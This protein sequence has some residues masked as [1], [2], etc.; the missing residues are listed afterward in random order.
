LNEVGADSFRFWAASE[1][2][3]G[4]DFR[5]SRERIVGASKFMTK[6]WNISKFISM[7]GESE[8]PEKL[9]ETDR[10]ILAELGKLIKECEKGYKSYDFFVPANTI[11]DFVWNIF[12]PHYIELVKSRAYEGNYSASYTL[13]TVL[14]NVLKLLA[15]ICPFM[16]DKIYRELYGKSVH[17]ELFPKTKKEWESKYTKLTQDL[18]D[19]NSAIWKEKKDKNMSLASDIEATIPKRLATF[20][21]DLKA[22]HR[23]K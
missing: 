17:K 21:R 14:K 5:I 20:E 1:T 19:F 11:R 9:E 15:P 7:F 23:L 13:H 22:M 10:W 6:L 12:A 8:E 18:V 4:D 2:K 3:I 16:T